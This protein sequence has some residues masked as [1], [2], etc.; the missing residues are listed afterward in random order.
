MFSEICPTVD[1]RKHAGL[2]SSD[3]SKQEKF[4][5]VTYE[6]VWSE[7]PTYLLEGKK[8]AT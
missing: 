5:G 4:S 1:D 3:R 6:F 7:V 8:R 2:R